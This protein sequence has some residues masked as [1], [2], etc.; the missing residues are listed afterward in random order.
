MQRTVVKEGGNK[1]RRCGVIGVTLIVTI[2]VCYCLFQMTSCEKQTGVWE[3]KANPHKES[4]EESG[5]EFK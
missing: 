2:G 5:Q 3:R 4:Y 1:G